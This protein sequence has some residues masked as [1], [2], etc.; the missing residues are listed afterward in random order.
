MKRAVLPLGLFLAALAACGADDEPASPVD[1]IAADPLSGGET[2]VFDRTQGAYANQAKNLSNETA[3]LFSFGHSV[4]N[5]NWVVAPATTDGM[6]G[7]GPRF[8]QRSCSGCH[9]RDGR[10]APLNESGKQRGLLFRLSI[11]G[12]SEHGGPLGDPVYGD[13]LRPAAIPGVTPDG[14]P[15][16]TYAEQPGTY[17]DGAPFSLRVPTYAITDWGYGP[18][19]P[20]FLL[21]PRTGPFVIGL[22]LLEAIPD[23]ALLANVRKGDPDGVVGHANRVWSD[24]RQAMAVGRFGWKANVANVLDQSAGALLGDIGITSRLHLV[25]TCSPTMASCLAAPSDGNAYQ[26]SDDKLHALDVYMRTLAVPARRDLEEPTTKR[27]AELFASFRC[28]TC[29][30][31]DF[32]T[33]PSDIAEVAN[34]KIHPYT[35]LLLHDMGPGLADGRPDFEAGPGEWRTPPLW[36][37]GLL[38]TVNGHEFLLHDGRARGYEEAILWHD[39]EAKAS[40]ERFRDANAADRAALVT[41]LRSL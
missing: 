36:G 29:H 30:V 8:N 10:S 40:R 12:A 27:G 18:A 21:S 19:A 2:T 39:G 22:G 25:E 23:E 11:P 13:Q 6:D 28:T 9:L 4:F 3:S 15:T 37:I 33:G 35:D 38:E 5:R 14:V 24:S 32:T 7:L 41:F 17:G 16:T 20:G 26:I 31:T 34:Q 1:T